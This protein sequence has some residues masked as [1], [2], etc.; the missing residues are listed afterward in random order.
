MRATMRR[1]IAGSGSQ[2]CLAILEG[3]ISAIHITQPAL[4]R[5]PLRAHLLGDSFLTRSG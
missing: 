1:T 3:V 4:L 2:G 5:L